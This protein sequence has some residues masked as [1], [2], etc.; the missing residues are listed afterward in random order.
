[1]DELDER[2]GTAINLYHAVG[3][4]DVAGEKVIMLLNL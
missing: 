2:S 3:D 1:M 4:E